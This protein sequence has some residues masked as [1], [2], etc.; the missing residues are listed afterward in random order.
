MSGTE[1]RALFL[2]EEFRSGL[3]EISSYLASIMQEKPIVFLVAKCLWRLGRTFEL[4]YERQD[5]T[6]NGRH[7]E[8][9][10]NYDRCQPNL[11]RELALCG[12]DPN[13]VWELV[14]TKRIS[15]TW[16]VMAKISQDVCNK[17]PDV[18]VWVIC[19]RD[20]SKV[21]SDDLQRICRGKDQRKYNARFPYTPD[22]AHI[23]TVDS[24]L[25]KLQAI[26]PFSLLKQA[27]HTNGAFP[28]TY[29]FR[30]CDFAGK[31]V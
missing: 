19:S 4:E 24:F 23:A 16:A 9:K 22:E 1:L 11:A 10:F 18:F 7:I 25:E 20:L 30:I 27:I 8:F 26:R 29:H 17:K 3:E 28:S 5:L 21:S 14:R 6:V 15:K 13:N 31:P 2:S 12:G